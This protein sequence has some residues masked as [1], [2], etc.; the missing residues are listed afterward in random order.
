[1]DG[2]KHAEQARKQ[3]QGRRDKVD[4]MLFLSFPIPIINSHKQRKQAAR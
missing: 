1:M 4:L 2:L 3:I